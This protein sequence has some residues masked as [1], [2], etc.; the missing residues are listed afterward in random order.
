MT[1][2]ILG[3]GWLGLPLAARFSAK[4]YR[5]NG[6]T[7]TP[8]KISQLEHEGIT[9]YLIDLTT[10]DTDSLERFCSCDCLVIAHPPKH[11]P[12][13]YV[14]GIR[15]LLSHAPKSLIPVLISSTAVYP[16]LG[17][18]V[19]E[20]TPVTRENT[21]KPHIL[22]AEKLVQAFTPHH[23]IVRCAGLMGYERA[24]VRYFQNRPVPAAD[25]T[26]NQ[27]HRDDAILALEHLIEANA[28]GTYNLCAPLHPT[29]KALYTYQA[30]QLGLPLPQFEAGIGAF[31]IVN[32]E[33]VCRDTGFSY[34]YPDPMRFG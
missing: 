31:K 28:T 20:T 6:S 19:D 16:N 5:V 25:T 32:G 30:Q 27:V 9:P 29:K 18:T 13:A 7:T 21:P 22:E 11:R 8:E 23:L 26:V 34:R 4:G 17:K 12:E 33:K 14:E 2:S 15:R 24:G 3:C 1:L 10:A